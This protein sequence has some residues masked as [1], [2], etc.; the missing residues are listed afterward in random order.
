MSRAMSAS[1]LTTENFEV[2]L[3]A[4]CDRVTSECRDGAHFENSKAFERRVREVLDESVSKFGLAVNFDPHPYVFPDI[5][6]GKFGVEVKFTTNDTW[7]SVANSV[8]ESTRDANVEH[9]YLV[10]GKMG[11]EPAVAWGRYEE[12]VIHVRTSH[13]PRFEVELPPHRESLFTT[14]GIPYAD[15]SRLSEAERMEYVRKYAR[16]RLKKGEKL[17]W[18]ENGADEGHS[19]SLRAKRFQNLTEKDKRKIRAEACLL[20]PGIL[21]SS[22]A[23]GKYDEALMYMLTYHGILAGRDAFSAGSV[24]GKERGKWHVKRALMN[25]QTEI[26][27]AAKYLPD[28]L[29]VEYWGRA[30]PKEKRIPE[31]LKRAD[32]QAQTSDSPWK[33][34]EALFKGR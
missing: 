10:F 20:C 24:A 3:V 23:R 18:L 33:P 2:I 19:L 14:F 8:F 25:I 27:E 11:G 34:S 1:Q 5:V 26:L 9:I 29:F 16:D 22:R 4:L 13:V 6:L 21:K 12:C 30:V 17:W 28:A 15:F 31:W 7:R 32:A